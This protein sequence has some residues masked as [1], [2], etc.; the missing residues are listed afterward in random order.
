MRSWED[1][2][3]PGIEGEAALESS[4]R[5][6]SSD[7]RALANASMCL[8]DISLAHYMYMVTHSSST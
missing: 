8:H 7:S 5:V 4:G 6:S 1:R 3:V 2:G